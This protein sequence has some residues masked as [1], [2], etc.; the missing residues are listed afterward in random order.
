VTFKNAGCLDGGL[1][2]SHKKSKRAS[3]TGT[4]PSFGSIVQKGKFSAAACSFVN[5]LKKVLFPTFGKPT[6]PK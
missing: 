6:I 2:K 4:R 3:G 5:I 1:Y